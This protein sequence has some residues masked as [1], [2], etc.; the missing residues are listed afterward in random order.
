MDQRVLEPETMDDP[1]LDE[2][3]HRTALAGLARLNRVGRVAGSLFEAM[4][5]LFA[6][7]DRP[8]RVLDIATGGGDV[9]IRLCQLA[10]RS[11]LPIE[12]HGC[13]VSPVAV[14]FARDRAEGAGVAARFFRF[15]AV[16]DPLPRGYDVVTCSLFLHHLAREEAVNVLEKMSRAAETRVIVS[17]LDRRPRH[18]AMIWLA[19]HLLTRSAV[20]RVDG[21]R[22]L[23]AAFTVDEARA[24]AAEAGLH[25]ARVGRSFPCRFILTWDR[26]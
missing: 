1:S 17:D 14:E 24:M 26:H 2:S 11:G 21:P 4:R 15:N 23:R 6:G 18:R 12:V 10:R 8:L 5:D 9:P 22:S 13:D 25:G 3:E 20:V 7:R 19:T 16:R